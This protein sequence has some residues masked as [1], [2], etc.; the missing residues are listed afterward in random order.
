[1]AGPTTAERG[2]LGPQGGPGGPEGKVRPPR[3]GAPVER[4][5]RPGPRSLLIAFGALIAVAGAIWL[6]YGSAWLRAEHVE[7]TGTEVLT[8]REV[9]AVAAVPI[10]AP[11]ISVDT[12]AIEARLRQ[13][14]PRIDAVEVERSWPHGI[15]LVVTERKPVLLLEKGA[16]FVEVDARSV[17]F[18]TVATAPKGVPLLRLKVDGSASLNRFGA[19][20]LVAE[21]VRVRSEL[22]AKVAADLRSMKV[23]S[24]DYISLELSGDRSVVWGSPEAGEAKARALTAL[25]KAAPKAGHF[26]VSAPSAPA[27]SRS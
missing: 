14:L 13:E 25:M 19:D 8:P 21:A 5:P 17:R 26:D 20:R 1:M 27:V 6:L 3:K 15:E 22:P 7:T 2:A 9:E 4:F 12:D 10:G 23:V 16:K 24:Y 11:L 18:A